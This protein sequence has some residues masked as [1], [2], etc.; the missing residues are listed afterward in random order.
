[1]LSILVSQLS[2]CQINNCLCR[3]TKLINVSLSPKNFQKNYQ[4]LKQCI[5]NFEEKETLKKKEPNCNICSCISV[6]KLPHNICFISPKNNQNLNPYVTNFEEME[7]NAN[8]CPWISTAKSQLNNQNLN[9]SVTNFEEK[10]T[11]C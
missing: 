7:L 5:P 10:A 4:S 6:I 11:K 2:N 1:M 3:A 9:L 8:T